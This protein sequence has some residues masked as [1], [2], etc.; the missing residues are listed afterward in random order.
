MVK[1]FELLNIPFFRGLFRG[2]HVR[3]GHFYLPSYYPMEMS[4]PDPVHPAWETTSPEVNL[5]FITNNYLIRCV[6]ES[7]TIAEGRSG[8]SH[9]GRGIGVDAGVRPQLA[10]G[11]RG[12]ASGGGCI[13][14][15]CIR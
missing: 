10:G 11:G 13:A 1:L 7:A 4:I 5:E 15:N 12:V 2:L 14:G 6:A 3:Y 8:E 9:G